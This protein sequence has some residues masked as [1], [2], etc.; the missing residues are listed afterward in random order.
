MISEVDAQLG[1]IWAAVKAGRRLGRHD[2]HPHLRP[3]R[4]DGRP[5]PARQRRLLR[6]Q[7]PHPADRPRP[8]PERRPRARSVDRFTE[9]VDIMPTLLDLLGAEA[10]GASR[11]QFAD[12]VPRRA[13]AGRLARRGALGVRFPLDRERRGR[14]GISASSRSNAIW[15]S[16]AREKF[17]YVHF[18]GGLPPLLFDLENDPGELRNLA[19]RPGLRCPCGS[20]FAER[21]LAWRAEHLDQSLALSGA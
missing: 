2:R 20:T 5:F 6:R 12:A 4:D 13:D 21:L 19:E 8:A 3:C 15:P 18:G 10:A 16:S 11:R 14:D 17:K 9:A 1:R 7:L